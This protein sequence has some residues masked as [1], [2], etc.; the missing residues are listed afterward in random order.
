MKQVSVREA[1]SNLSR[2]LQEVAAG[3]DVVITRSGRPVAK[4][5]NVEEGRPIL[6]IDQGQFVVP[7][8]FDTP[9]NEDLLRAFEGRL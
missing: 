3:Q 1:K 8:D 9:L 7:E 6:G 5:V 2:L 4:L